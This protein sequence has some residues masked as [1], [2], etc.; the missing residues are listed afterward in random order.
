MNAPAQSTDEPFRRAVAHC[1]RSS[2]PIS[3]Y[4]E[5]AVKGVDFSQIDTSFSEIKTIIGNR[6]SAALGKNVEDSLNTIAKSGRLDALKPKDFQGSMTEFVRQV[7]QERV[8]GL[9]VR[10]CFMDWLVT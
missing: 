4:I 5:D 6:A 9:A 3:W 8:V 2:G 1:V 10:R 7:A